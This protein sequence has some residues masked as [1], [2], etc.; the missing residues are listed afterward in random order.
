MFFIKNRAMSGNSAIWWRAGGH[1]Y[2]ADLDDAGRFTLE[3]A[4]RITRVRPKEDEMFPV[5]AVEPLAKRHVS[6]YALAQ[7]KGGSK[8]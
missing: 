2:T 7:I 3:E 1:G 8:T 4:Q 6:V 5:E